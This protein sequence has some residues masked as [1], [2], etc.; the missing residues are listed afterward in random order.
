MILASRNGHVEIVSLL[1]ASRADLN[2]KLNAKDNE[3]PNAL[4]LA[5]E[6]GRIEI[7]QLLI[8]KGADLN[9]KNGGERGLVMVK[10]RIMMAKLR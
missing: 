8:E 6:H 4:I 3:G 10:R 1:I 2:A 7:A 9:A 5:L